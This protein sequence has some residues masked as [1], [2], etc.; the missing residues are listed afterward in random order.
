MINFSKF[1][2]ELLIKRG[3]KSKKTK[4][5]FLPMH[6]IIASIKI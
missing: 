4:S 1:V 5:Y 2:I 3:R 6:K